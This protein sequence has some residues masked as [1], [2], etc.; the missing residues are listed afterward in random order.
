MRQRGG[1]QY[2]TFFFCFPLPL[3][4]VFL[5][6]SCQLFLP[7]T[8]VFPLSSLSRDHIFCESRVEQRVFVFTH[9]DTQLSHLVK[10]RFHRGVSWSPYSTLVISPEGR[11]PLTNYLTNWQLFLP[12]NFLPSLFRLKILI[13][14]F[15][16]L[17]CYGLKPFQ[18]VYLVVYCRYIVLYYHILYCFAMDFSLHL[19]QS[20]QTLF[21]GSVTKKDC[22]IIGKFLFS[23]VF[24]W[25]IWWTHLLPSN[26]YKE[27]QTKTKKKIFSL[28]NRQKVF[29]T[30][31]TIW[32]CFCS[33]LCLTFN[34]YQS[35]HYPNHVS[36]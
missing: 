36:C 2:F 23:S 22:I 18:C 29:C 12:V 35:I 14:V 7:A 27:T 28:G 17:R 16:F 5:S 26:K 24:W 13:F 21:R 8:P 15:V 4:L 6:V 32:Y 20:L 3:H 9:T 33:S 11:R 19:F 10:L 30:K 34:F 25:S 31:L 1:L